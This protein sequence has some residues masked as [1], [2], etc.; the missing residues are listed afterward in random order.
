MRRNRLAER[1]YTDRARISRTEDYE[2]TYGETRLQPD[3]LIYD[4]VP[5]RISQK[6]LAVNGQTE[7]TNRIAYETKLFL[8]SQYKIKQGDKIAVTRGLSTRLYTA[9]EPFLYADHQE[10][11]LQ[12]KDNA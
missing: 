5:C 11:S 10:I 8:S 9:G 2:T 1:Y 3:L 4:G 6:V 7:T 12:R